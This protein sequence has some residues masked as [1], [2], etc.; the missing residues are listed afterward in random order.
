MDSENQ[1]K[2][3][4]VPE[5][6]ISSSS[7][8]L[9]FVGAWYLGCFP[10]LSGSFGLFL[11]SLAGLAIVLPL[12]CKLFASAESA[13]IVSALGVLL[14]VCS[15]TG[16][17]VMTWNWDS[18]LFYLGFY[19]LA[20][21]FFHESEFLTTA[22]FNP[23]RLSL[24]SYILN[25]STEYHVAALASWTEYALEYWL[26]PSLKSYIWISRTGLVLVI[27]GEML[28][29]MAMFTARSNF[30]HL[31]AHYKQSDHELVSHGVYGLFRHPSYVGWFY[32][33]VGTQLLLCNPL[34]VMA[35]AAASW[36]FFSERI[37][38][39]EEALLRFFGKKYE[40]Y[41][42][43][44]GTGLPFIRGFSKKAV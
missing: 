38:D 3:Q 26:L 29:K 7:Y 32:W 31:V 20:L 42:K 15:G 35:Y 17:L 33:S 5:L 2:N 16:V 44:V 10:A 30:S 8:L 13:E 41:Q 28:R 27:C 40:E 4:W 43:T 34:C 19:I 39:E 23:H 1:R 25:H 18:P 12:T 6:W 37:E 24:D 9:P 21:S 36:M 11:C 22:L 14:G